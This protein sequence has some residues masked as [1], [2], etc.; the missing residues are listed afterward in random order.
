MLV[1]TIVPVRLPGSWLNATFALD[2]GQI[3]ERRLLAGALKSD[4]DTVKRQGA[5]QLLSRVL[6][7]RTLESLA[8]NGGL[9]V[10]VA[11]V[12]LG[13]AARLL[14]VGPANG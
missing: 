4:L 12:E 2:A 1:P 5:G 3:L 8:L 9:S 6:E 11:V 7:S 10:L 13:F 14:A